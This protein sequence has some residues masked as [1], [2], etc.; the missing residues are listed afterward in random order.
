MNYG[1]EVENLTKIYPNLKLD[2]VT[3]QV[4]QGSIMGLVGENGA[5]KTTTI[6]AMLNMIQT[7]SGE[8]R[9]MGKKM[10]DEDVEL[11]EEIGVVF[12]TVNFSPELTACRL[13]KV[14]SE[15]YKNWDER[16]YRERLEQLKIPS[17]KKIGKFSRG[18]T[19][20]LSIAVALSHGAKILILDEATSGLDPIVREEILDLFLEFVEDE[21]R[22]VLISSHITSDLEKVADYITFMHQGKVVLVERKD[23]LIYEYG[24]ARCREREFMELE[25]TEYLAYR[26]RGLQTDVLVSD[27]KKFQARH[28]QILVDQAGID[29]I[30]LLIVKG[31]R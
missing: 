27:R 29:E 5:G 2:S 8:I 25:K 16:G 6:S 11:R 23:I 1:I 12:D 17:D 22:T 19:M 20:K 18:M 30:M 9:I 26:K 31:E 21:K 10:T 7:D 4:P 28:S 13:S 15:I 14:F 3:F 24:I